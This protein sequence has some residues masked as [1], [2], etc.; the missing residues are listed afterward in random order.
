MYFCQKS[1]YSFHL[2]V[3]AIL[4]L[5]NLSNYMYVP[6][7]SVKHVLQPYISVDGANYITDID[8]DMWFTVMN[9]VFQK[10]AEQ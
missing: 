6:F 10:C 9:Y 1:R 4:K 3:H 8:N 5:P 2:N 7:D